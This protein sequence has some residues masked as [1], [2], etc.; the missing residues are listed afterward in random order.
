MFDDFDI[1]KIQ[2]EI[3]CDLNNSA[4]NNV[5]NINTPTETGLYVLPITAEHFYRETIKEMPRSKASAGWFKKAVAL[6]LAFTLG[7]GTLGFGIGAGVGRFMQRENATTVVD[8]TTTEP[9]LTSVVPTF[10]IVES[11]GVGTLADI[12]E[13]LTPAVVSVTTRLDGGGLMQ[14][15]RNGSGLIFGEDEERIFIVTNYYIVRDG[16]SQFG[17]SIA[18]SE[19]L[20]ATPIGVD[21]AVDLAVLSIEKS[22]LVA[23]G[24][25]RI[26]IATFGDS[27]QM[28]VGDTVLA[29]GNAMGEG[30]AV[31]RG[32]I[33]A[34]EKTVILPIGGHTLSL[35]QTDAAINYGN[36]GG[37]LVNTRGEVIGININQASDIMFGMSN[38]EGIGYSIASNIAAPI[39]DDLINRRRPALGIRGGT[40]SEDMAERLGI[41]AI[42]VYVSSVFETGAAFRGGMQ[43]ADVITGFNGLPV[44]NWQQLVDALRQSRVG[45]IVEVRVLRY[46]DTAITLYVELDA[47]LVE[48][49]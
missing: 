6:V 40:I 10:D 49:F 39:L 28:R 38:V 42:G 1:E 33:S 16:G 19:P 34:S 46:G 32:I 26:I 37:P 43:E 15:V 8:L 2:A 47:M 48:N 7:T 11:P 17:V 20:V 14:F 41:P 45:D 35:M 12:V 25:D 5:S 36:S 13:A 21:S 9:T 30:N 4:S 22:V 24:I 3:E 18:G 29:I 31:T 27:D 23:A 44:F